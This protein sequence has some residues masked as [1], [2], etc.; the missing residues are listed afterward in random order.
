MTPV[1]HAGRRLPVSGHERGQGEAT[2]VAC[3]WPRV[4]LALGCP[5][6]SA[7]PEFALFFADDAAIGMERVAAA[8][9]AAAEA[10]MRDHHPDAQLHAVDGALVTEENR[11]R[12]LGD[13]ARGLG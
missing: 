13:W 4:W 8:N 7:M 2:F 11:L 12:L 5:G 9:A 10:V 6:N 1:T 3:R